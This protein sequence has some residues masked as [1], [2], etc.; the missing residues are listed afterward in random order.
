MRDGSIDFMSTIRTG[1]MTAQK[2]A[3]GMPNTYTVQTGADCGSAQKTNINAPA[4]YSIQVVTV[5]YVGDSEF[6]SQFGDRS[7]SN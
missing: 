1:R 7:F 5:T 6:M 3:A 4:E 2:A